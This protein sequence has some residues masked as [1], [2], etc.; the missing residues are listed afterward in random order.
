ML[1]PTSEVNHYM[2]HKI[3]LKK[4]SNGTWVCKTEGENIGE[5]RLSGTTGGGCHCYCCKGL[6]H[7]ALQSTQVDHGKPH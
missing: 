5:A 1:K 3:R 2:L 6:C 7:G 4:S